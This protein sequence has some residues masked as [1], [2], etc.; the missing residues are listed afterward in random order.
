MH[1][2]RSFPVSFRRTAQHVLDLVH[3]SDGPPVVVVTGRAGAG[4]TAVLDAVGK[5]LRDQ[6]R[7]VIDVQVARDG[8]LLNGYGGG[9]ARHGKRAF[10][11]GP[12]EDAHDDAA[13]ARRVAAAAAAP[14]VAGDAVVLIDDAQWLDRDAAA[15]LEALAHRLAGTAV[16]YVCAIALHC[17]APLAASGTA[18]VRRLRAEGLAAS[19]RV[20]PLDA[21]ETAR[22]VQE[23]VGAIP[24]P[25]LVAH[26]R[27][28]SRGIPAA[29]MAET[30]SLRGAG[31]LHL[32]SGYAYLVP[33]MPVDVT[34]TASLLEN[35]RRLGPR[36]WRT[37]CTAAAL[38]PAGPAL[39]PLLAVALETPVDEA[40]A[41]L[42]ELRTAGVLH[43]SREAGW[44][45]VVPVLRDGLRAEL[46]PYE[47]RMLAALVVRAVWRG[48][49]RVSPPELADLVATA[50][51][52]LPPDRAH[53]E[54]VA[55]AGR[56]LGRT[57]RR[58]A[59][60]WHVAAE[61][62]GPAEDRV[63]AR[64]EHARA[65]ERAGDAPG[66]MAAA[67]ELL[68]DENA[69]PEG[70]RHELLYMLVRG[71]QATGATEELDAIANGSAALEG[72]EAIQAICRVLALVL[73]GRWGSAHSLLART[74]VV[75]AASPATREVGEMIM[76]IGELFAGRV[77]FVAGRVVER[78]SGCAPPADR[79]YRTDWLVACMIVLGDVR[80]ARDVALRV[81]K[82]ESELL[83]P[84]RAVVALLEGRPEAPEMARRALVDP[85]TRGFDLAAAG[86]YEV[87]ASLLLAGGQ[88]AAVRQ[89]IATARPSAPVLDHV[90][91][92]SEAS[93]DLVL[94]DAAAARA[95]LESALDRARDN[96]LVVGTDQLL[97]L[98]LE[99]DRLGGDISGARA[100]STELDDVAAALQ[101]PRAS[102]HAAFGRALAYDDEVAAAACL[103][104]AQDS[105][106]S[107]EWAHLA[108]RLARAGLTDPDVLVDVY[109]FYGR[110][111]VLLA[112][113]WTRS[114]M[115]AR[116]VP[117]PGRAVTKAENERLL[118]Q[119]L[120]EGFTNRQ[121]AT[122]LGSSE[123]SVEGRLGRLFSRTGYRSRIELAAALLKGGYAP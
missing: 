74:R 35:V 68:D 65:C 30:S 15:V 114:V 58:R 64:L 19:V 26:V 24:S 72:D 45:F 28:R 2:R 108:L 103:R 21:D 117:V 109:A 80:G 81:G 56:E 47:R 31:G 99:I 33:D 122:L 62:A 107:Y 11:L 22:A 77:R 29:V 90:L 92:V 101:S 32:V 113:A 104:L 119:L 54:L 27:A 4:R 82:A 10:S 106:Q 43:H 6:G 36:A 50:G 105:G 48:G 8:V 100:R 13:T 20:A 44:R 60:W 40:T 78:A 59:R 23:A 55:A 37:A 18:A 102:A 94:G 120:T 17:P 118:G 53:A 89:L 49:A 87:F 1:G 46:G 3:D 95:R 42:H 73:R 7:T 52:L 39:P 76:W 83:L 84:H 91:D 110:L 66:A 69:L 34:D 25:E 116:G 88:I 97:S 86:F 67:R 12:A 75:W 9:S 123:K 41:R 51:R 63:R 85:R 61:L 71:L 98:L 121:I 16:R 111:D 112:R 14:L 96:D 79:Q 38:E 5:A 93:I 57:S 115:E 70:A